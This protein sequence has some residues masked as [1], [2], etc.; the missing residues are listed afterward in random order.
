MKLHDLVSKITG[1]DWDKGNI[2]K[3]W[4]KHGVTPPEC[5]DVFFNQPL[6]GIDHGHSLAE[7]RYYAYGSTD[8]GRPL[9]IVFTLRNNLIRV[10]S[11]R[12]MN[13][14]ERTRYHERA[15]KDPEIQI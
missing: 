12:P 4:Q 1:F 7:Q 13:K 11:A 2:D 10:T 5:E 6:I 9:F 15:K 3:N 8:A 14:K